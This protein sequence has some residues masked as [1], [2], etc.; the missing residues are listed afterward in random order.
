MSW[1]NSSENIDV[2]LDN[3][4]SGIAVMRDGTLK[5]VKMQL[6]NEYLPMLSM[7]SWR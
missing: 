5:L 2:Q 1:D 4:Y 6:E 3:I 7:P